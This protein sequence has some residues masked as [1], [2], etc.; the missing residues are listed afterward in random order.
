MLSEKT[1]TFNAVAMQ[2]YL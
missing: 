1:K 2:A